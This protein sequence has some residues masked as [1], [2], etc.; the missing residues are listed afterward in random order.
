M[1]DRWKVKKVIGGQNWLDASKTGC[2]DG[3]WTEL[4]QDRVQW[5]ALELIVFNFRVL[6]LH[7]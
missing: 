4:P 7:I 5:P 2:E 3:R 1:Y 6:V